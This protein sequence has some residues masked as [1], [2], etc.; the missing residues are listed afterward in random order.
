[1]KSMRMLYAEGKYR[2]V[3]AERNAPTRDRSPT[4]SAFLK[5][6]QGAFGET[7]IQPVRETIDLVAADM[8]PF[9]QHLKVVLLVSKRQD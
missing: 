4:I 2:S 1:M 5:V 9:E 3:N 8:A 6:V 7:D